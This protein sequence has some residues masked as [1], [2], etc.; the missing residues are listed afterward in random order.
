MKKYPFIS[1][2]IC[3]QNRAETLKN[4]A[5]NSILK[6][7]YPTYE[8]VIVDDDSKDKTQEILKEFKNKIKN[9]IIIKNTK[10][11]GLCYARNLGI[12]FT[13]G[14]IIAFIDDDCIVD[15]NWLNELIKP[16]L[17]NK[18]M[19]VVGGK[20][21]VGNS[22]KIYNS[23]KEII[24]CNMSF[25]KKIFNRFL[26]DENLYFNKSGLHDETELIYRIKN[27]NLPI[28][29]TDKAIVKHF[30]EPAEYRKNKKIGGPLN[31]IYLYTK[32]T[33]LIT[34]YFLF[35]T[36]LLFGKSKKS[37]L[38]TK[39]KEII[40]KFD[41]IRGLLAI[42]HKIYSKLPWIF[43]VLLFEI[44]FK[45]KI[46]NRLEKIKYAINNQE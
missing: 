24:G 22:N 25:R 29:Y 5:L 1:I 35:I 12:K 28:T 27:K 6:L 10:A 36:T 7:D 32:E 44:P 45:A 40:N 19:M 38:P 14:E 9:L 13:K 23:Q 42:K 2:V 3:T 46:K 11:K 20:I 41:S 21:Y 33:S 37:N 26:F 4:Y 8:V 43:Y 31:L 39:H 30:I 16:Y 18:N 34:Y 17:K 15:K